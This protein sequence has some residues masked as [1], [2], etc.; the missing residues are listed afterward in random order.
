M[1]TGATLEC[2]ATS[3][4][5]KR[6]NQEDLWERV[7]LHSFSVEVSHSLLLNQDIISIVVIK[8]FLTYV[9]HQLFGRDNFHF[10][11]HLHHQ[12]LG[13]DNP[14]NINIIIIVNSNLGKIVSQAKV[15]LLI[16]IMII[17]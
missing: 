11:H 15:G 8:R 14:L 6:K 4:I 5:K 2:R 13:Q 12:E 7:L 17:K 16:N 9:N 1:E 3:M 10:N